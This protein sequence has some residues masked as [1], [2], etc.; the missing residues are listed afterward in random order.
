MT[1][2]ELK[3][4]HLGACPDSHFFDK[5]TMQFFGDTMSN[6]GVVHDTERGVYELRRKRP[7]KYGNQESA[8]FDAATFQIRHD[9]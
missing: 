8:Y 5:E 9:L 7:V 1:A 6:Y 3:A 4:K 2:T